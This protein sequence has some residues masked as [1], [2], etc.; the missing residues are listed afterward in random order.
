MRVREGWREPREDTDL[1]VLREVIGQKKYLDDHMVCCGSG[2]YVTHRSPI[3][4]AM[5]LLVFGD[6]ST[7]N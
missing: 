3:R 1:N 2:A 7:S 4:G 5:V 6:E